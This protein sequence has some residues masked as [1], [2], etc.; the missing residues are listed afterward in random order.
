MLVQLRTN[1]RLCP[2]SNKL[3]IDIAQTVEVFEF[4]DSFLQACNISFSSGLRKACPAVN[5][6]SPPTFRQ[7]KTKKRNMMSFFSQHSTILPCFEFFFIAYPGIVG[8][9]LYHCTCSC[10]SP[11]STCTCTCRSLMINSQSH[12]Q[13]WH[14]STSRSQ[15]RHRAWWPESTLR[16]AHQAPGSTKIVWG[17]NV[18][19]R[20]PPVVE[21]RKLERKDFGTTRS[22]GVDVVDHKPIWM[23]SQLL[24]SVHSA[25]WFLQKYFVL[26]IIKL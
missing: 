9:L 19:V 14:R 6:F 4:V 10:H 18:S 26:K 23:G 5:C 7:N 11:D 22:D 20:L 1:L 21:D 17:R 24:L 16:R 12:T 3:A 2:N 25:S 13:I 15:E 8:L